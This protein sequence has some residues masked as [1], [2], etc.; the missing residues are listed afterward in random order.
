MGKGKLKK[1][2]E[3]ETYPF[4]VQPER[5]NVLAGLD[6]RGTWKSDFFKNDRPLVLEIGC[7]RGEYT[8]A[9]AQRQPEANYVG[10]DIK[11]NRL[12]QGARIIAQEGLQNAG[13]LRTRVELLDR[14][15]APGEVDEIWITF[16][17]PQIKHGRAKH[18]LTAPDFLRRYAHF[19]KPNGLVHLKTDSEFLHGYTVGL[20]EALQLPVEEA[21]YDLDHQLRPNFP[22]HLLLQV[23]TY[24]EQ[25][26]AGKGKTITY[27]RF[28]LPSDAFAAPHP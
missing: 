4:V 5:E 12:V 16:P 27:L 28:R 25:L 14:C 19:L 22:N 13:F 6:L 2:A 24:Y 18:R 1:F 26:F 10:I 9:L 11:G 23:K 3:L 20:C 8:V 7:G 21:Y 15:F 17:D